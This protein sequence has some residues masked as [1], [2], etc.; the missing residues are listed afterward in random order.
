MHNDL[1][2]ENVLM[3]WDQARREW[4]VKLA[5][6]GI[7]TCINTCMRVCAR[8]FACVCHNVRVLCVL[9]Y[10]YMSMSFPRKNAELKKK[11]PHATSSFEIWCTAAVLQPTWL[12][13][14]VHH[15]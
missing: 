5:D 8:A 12:T 7:R 10:M 3:K 4:I 13:P 6:Y 11:F 2:P 14:L 9:V 15:S 1:K